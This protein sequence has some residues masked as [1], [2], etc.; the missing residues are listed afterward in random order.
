[1][2]ENEGYF[3]L[4]FKAASI[5]ERDAL[6]NALNQEGIEGK[7]SQRDISRKITSTMVDLAY[8]GYSAVFDGFPIFVRGEDKDG[9]RKII[10]SFFLEITRSESENLRKK[11]RHLNRFYFCALYSLLFPVIFH[12]YGF[13]HLKE[14]LKAKEHIQWIYFVASIVLYVLGACL[15]VY[16]ARNVTSLTQPW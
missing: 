7:T 16:Y 15:A 13:H 10:E 4:V 11:P 6:L 2:E 3:V 1:M 9:A 5:I 8:E 12:V 14:G